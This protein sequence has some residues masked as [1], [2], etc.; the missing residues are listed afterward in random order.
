MQTAFTLIINIKQPF[1]LF[2]LSS[3]GLLFFSQLKWRCKEHATTM[4]IT[5]T[6]HYR[7]LFVRNDFEK[8]KSS[9]K[10]ETSHSLAIIFFH[11]PEHS[12]W[13]NSRTIICV[14]PDPFDHQH[15][16]YGILS[17]TW[18]RSHYFHSQYFLLF[19]SGFQ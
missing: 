8:K 19:L 11:S 5:I 2:I 7:N 3:T 9:N 18:Y 16:F 6:F 13:G 15:H 1:N 10:I 17:Y 14:C 12:L 4:A